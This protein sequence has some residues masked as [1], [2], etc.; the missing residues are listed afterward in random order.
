MAYELGLASRSLRR[1]P[2]Y[3]V[4]VVLVLSIGTGTLLAALLFGHAAILR[5]LDGVSNP[6]DLV[7]VLMVRDPKSHM[8]K[9]IVDA[10]SYPDFLDF[11]R[12]ARAVPELAGYSVRDM[13]VRSNGSGDALPRLVTGAVVSENY[14]S[15]LGVRF[16]MGRMFREGG[17][18]L[19]APFEV[20]IG[21]HTWQDVL[22]GR[23]DV[24]GSSLRLNGED[25][26]VVGVIADDF[27]GLDPDPKR[28]EQV[29][30]AL[31]HQPLLA[32]AWR[33]PYS[34]LDDRN[35]DWVQAIGRLTPAGSF[36]EA[37]VE[38][39]T[40]GAA[41]LAEHTEHHDA[42]VAFDLV[43]T[44]KPFELHP[45]QQPK[46]RK[47]FR[48]LAMACF[49]LLVV[50]ITAAAGMAMARAAAR[51]DE[52]GIRAALGADSAQIV[53]PLFAEAVILAAPVS[54]FGTA[55]GLLGCHLLPA[56]IFRPAPGARDL[57]PGVQELL[58]PG[59]GLGLALGV[60]SVSAC[61]FGPIVQAVLFRRQALA[62]QRLQLAVPRTRVRSGLV[63]AQVALTTILL[64][65]AG[66]LSQS[67][68]KMSKVD[69]GFLPD[70]LLVARF[71]LRLTGH[72]E[73]Q[74]RVFFDRLEERIEG[75]PGVESA[76]TSGQLPFVSRAM[77]AIGFRDDAQPSGLR[78]DVLECG[79]V[80]PS[81]F[82]ALGIPIVSGR[83]FE[84]GDF[85]IDPPPAIVNQTFVDTYAPGADLAELSR[86]ASCRADDFEPSTIVGVVRDHQVLWRH[87]EPTPLFY[88]F[89]D[90]APSAW[91]VVRTDDDPLALVPSLRQMVKAVDP[92]VPVVSAFSMRY[93]VDSLTWMERLLA[94]FATVFGMATLLLSA[95]GIYGLVAFSVEMRRKEIG[96]RM[97]LGATQWRVL[98][99]IVRH[100][101]GLASLGL[102]LGG[103]G[104]VPLA[105]SLDAFLYEMEALDPATYFAVGLTLLAAS[106]LANWIPA[107]RATSIEPARALR[108]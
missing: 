82:E 41:S 67:I 100:G 63:V 92:D 89:F 34:W 56:A 49:L 102:I 53:R 44:A 68:E 47:T 93:A 97:A 30:A 105:S 81:H 64:M 76:T 101:V 14:F 22:D 72:D 27:R 87:S 106:G 45:S 48:L 75:L 73:T 26:T 50:G 39:Q 1:N 17:N 33:R 107:R 40:L 29:W 23:S 42:R 62:K 31:A 74:A 19:A 79:L 98:D 46:L 55:L 35:T 69:L 65:C 16:S 4:V 9:K 104:I 59:I 37:R 57:L 28:D 95:L 85:N 32:P 60:F 18:D 94:R 90:S 58:L 12:R 24:L 54:L 8:P 88:E 13:S 99:L 83:G 84:A 15:V 43:R 5:P 108:E 6:R 20:V 7:R 10:I 3:T 86:L 91:F 103:L 77:C 96:V 71:D 38:F 52:L 70:G 25:F 66:L 11:R 36:E 2:A 61:C 80:G 78:H 21:H 51:N